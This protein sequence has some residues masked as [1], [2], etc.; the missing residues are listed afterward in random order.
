MQRVEIAMN[1][2]NWAGFLIGPSS[3]SLCL[4]MY[5]VVL[6]ASPIPGTSVKIRG[7][8][9]SS[10]NS[11]TEPT[12]CQRTGVF[13]NSGPSAK[14]MAGSRNAEAA[15]APAAWV[16]PVMN[17]RRVTVSPSNAPG[18]PRSDVYLDFWR[19]RGSSGIGARYSIRRDARVPC[20]ASSKW[21]GQ[22]LPGGL[23]GLWI[24]VGL[25]L[26]A[27]RD[28]LREG[29]DCREITGF[30]QAVE[31]QRVQPIARQQSQIG[32]GLGDDARVAGVQALTLA[33]GGVGEGLAVVRRPVAE[34]ARDESGLG[35]EQGVQVAHAISAKAAAA[36]SAV[37][38]TCSL[39]WAS[40]G[41]QA[42]NCEG[43]A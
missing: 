27:G 39:V 1:W 28:Q 5:A 20:H 34:R 15:T 35:H 16:V 6:P 40:D 22:S 2:P 3:D 42:S 26:R 36:A 13:S 38:S 8:Y 7:T 32:V 14:P 10:G 41:N 37:R 31:P 33:D 17:R 12:S 18:I 19:R 9:V 24:A 43:G 30:G 11:S 4:R 25:G 21:P 23:R 29:G